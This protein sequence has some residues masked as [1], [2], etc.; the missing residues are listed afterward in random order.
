M[1]DPAEIIAID[2]GVL[3]SVASELTAVGERVTGVE[4]QLAAHP[5]SVSAFGLMNAWMAPPVA[6]LVSHVAE[7]VQVSAGLATAVGAATRTAAADFGANETAI[8][9]GL[10]DLERQLD[11]AAGRAILR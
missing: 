2:P 3:R 4:T 7:V 8:V 1:A 5:L 11:D 9:D 6:A 10:H